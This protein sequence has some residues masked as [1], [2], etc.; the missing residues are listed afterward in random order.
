MTPSSILVSSLLA[1]VSLSSARPA[2]GPDVLSKASPAPAPSQQF[3]VQAQAQAAV[4]VGQIITK[5]TQAGTVALTFDDGPYIYTSK[6]LDILRDNNVKATFFVNGQNWGSI[7][8]AGNQ[9]IVR[10]IVNDGHLL[11]SHTWS[12]PDLTTL[13]RAGIES[14]LN[15][16]KDTLI[17]LIGKYPTYFRAPYF[18]TNSLV[19]ETA[20][21]LGYH[22]INA[23]IDTL[24]WR[25]KDNIQTSVQ[26][27]KDGLNAGGS[28]ALAHDVHQPTADTLAAAMVSEVK[29]RGLRAVTVGECLGDPAANWYRT[30]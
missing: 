4:P 6:I 20:G 8:E 10:R 25:Y 28:I 21:A 9:A 2:S 7:N 30:R 22:V 26:L 27:F 24:D 11:G 16:L 17:Q 19:L 18:A 1:L 15:Q 3:R 14:Q 13:N 12:H 5:C 23:D 29:R